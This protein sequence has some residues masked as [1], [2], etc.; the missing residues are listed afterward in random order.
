MLGATEM[1]LKSQAKII[2][3]VAR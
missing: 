3:P 1:V 2:T